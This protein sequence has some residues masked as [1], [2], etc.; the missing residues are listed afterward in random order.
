M[1]RYK[2]LWKVRNKC[3]INRQLFFLPLNKRQRERKVA[4]N[5]DCQ[6]FWSNLTDMAICSTFEPKEYFTE[7]YYNF[8]NW[9]VTW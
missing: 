9:S 1:F 3:R 6:S 2:L 5:I 7:G 4:R 8:L